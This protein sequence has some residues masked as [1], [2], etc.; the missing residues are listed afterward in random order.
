ML[1]EPKTDAER[2]CFDALTAIF[3]RSLTMGVTDDTKIAF[4]AIC[5]IVKEAEDG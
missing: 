5:E 2:I 1:P 4:D 3:N